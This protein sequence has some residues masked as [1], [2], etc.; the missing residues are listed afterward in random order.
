MLSFS[1]STVTVLNYV[2]RRPLLCIMIISLCFGLSNL[3][4]QGKAD[5]VVLHCDVSLGYTIT[6][7]SMALQRFLN[8]KYLFQSGR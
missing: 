3:I 7:S 2:E 1:N 4:S 6:V 5:A 8:L